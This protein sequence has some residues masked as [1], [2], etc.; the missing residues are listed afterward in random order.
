M[1]ITEKIRHIPAIVASWIRPN[2]KTFLITG[3]PKIWGLSLIIGVAV[4][5]AAIAFREA[6]GLVQLLWLD[7]RTENVLTS[8]RNVVLVL[9]DYRAD[10]RWPCFVGL[11]LTAAKRQTNRRRRRCHRGEGPCRPAARFP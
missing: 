10:L 7:T 5:I 2:I 11:L 4:G 1:A 8:A 6:I 3:Q 9:A